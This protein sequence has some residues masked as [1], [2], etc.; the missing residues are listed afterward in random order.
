M[1]Y[2]HTLSGMIKMSFIDLHKD[3]LPSEVT[4]IRNYSLTV[5]FNYVRFF[6]KFNRQLPLHRSIQILKSI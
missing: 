4:W 6:R 2:K 3:S 5:S 1:D